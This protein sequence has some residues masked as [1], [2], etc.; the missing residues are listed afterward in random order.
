M[1]YAIFSDIHSNLQ[2]Y[3]SLISDLK[4]RRPDKSLCLGDIVGYGANPGECIGM[5]K[6]L[7]C[8]VVCGNHDLA[9]TGNTPIINFNSSAKKAI[10]WTESV[11]NT[12]DKTYLGNLPLT[13]TDNS[14]T[15]VHGS[16]FMPHEFNYV[17]GFAD[18]EA[19]MDKQKTKLCFIGHSHI[20]GVF[21]KSA[22]GSIKTLMPST[23]TLE[24][25]TSYLINVGSVGQPRDNDW[26]ACYCVYDDT[27]G[28]LSFKRLEYDVGSA[29]RAILN[30]KLPPDLA[31]R[32]KERKRKR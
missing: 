3:E 28:V 17:S 25:N 26:R 21:A 10:I 2:A 1:L 29:S 15:L 20:P 12:A 24:K 30:A 16:L 27:K 9:S 18:A 14:V 31:F 19:S 7:N 6:K 32:L 11:L 8:P 5:T 23:I 22:D 13:Y 4:R